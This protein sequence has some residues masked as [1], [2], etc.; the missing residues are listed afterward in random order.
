MSLNINVGSL[1][2]AQSTA[3]NAD[4]GHSDIMFQC[5]FCIGLVRGSLQERIL[6]SRA[7]GSIERS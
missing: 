1:G 6:L 5:S 3:W 7:E 4:A 2:T